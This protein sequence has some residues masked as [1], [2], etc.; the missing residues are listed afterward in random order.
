MREERLTQSIKVTP[1]S[2]LPTRRSTTFVNYSRCPDRY[3]DKTIRDVLSARW[4]EERKAE[5]RELR[6][7]VF[8]SSTDELE[9]VPSSEHAS[10]SA[11]I[12]MRSK[13]ERRIT[14]IR[15]LG[16]T[17]NIRRIKSCASLGNSDGIVNLPAFTLANRVRMFS[18]SKGSRPV[19]RAKR[20][21]PQDQISE[22]AP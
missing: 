16:S 7:E 4:R 12:Q 6:E 19:R 9:F 22:E 2:Q 10:T 17:S 13:A 11:A 5:H 3:R 21:I 8:E 20:I 18:S 14:V 1:Q 15:S